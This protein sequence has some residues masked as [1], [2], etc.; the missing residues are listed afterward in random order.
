MGAYAHKQ[1]HHD[2][3]Y[4]DSSERLLVFPDLP[5]EDGEE[6]EEN[7]V[8]LRISHYMAAFVVTFSP[9]QVHCFGE[10]G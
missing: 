1:S 5:G 3:I 10:F 8:P 9:K 6:I 2:V 7:G 4:G